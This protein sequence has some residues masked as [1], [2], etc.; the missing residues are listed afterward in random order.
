MELSTDEGNNINEKYES[1]SLR[2]SDRTK[3][4][5]P[6][7]EYD[8]VADRKFVGGHILDPDL[9][10]GG[11][12]EEFGWNPEI[13]KGFAE[14]KLPQKSWLRS[15]EGLLTSVHNPDSTLMVMFHPDVRWKREMYRFRDN[16]DTMLTYQPLE[17]KNQPKKIKNDV[18]QPQRFNPYPYDNYLMH[19]DTGEK[20]DWQP[21]YELEKEDDWAPA[22]PKALIWWIKEMNVLKENGWIHLRPY[23]CRWYA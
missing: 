9:L 23:V 17:S 19:K 13:Q 15:A 16:L 8:S 18:I 22:P 3:L 20:Y 12:D 14:M 10:C 7:S 21:L 4:V 11:L 5:I 6:F 2:L 1:L